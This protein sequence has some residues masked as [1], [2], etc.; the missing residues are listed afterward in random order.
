MIGRHTKE[1]LHKLS[2]K[3]LILTVVCFG[4]YTNI[5]NDL[6]GSE[7]PTMSWV[8]LFVVAFF[9]CCESLFVFFLTDKDVTKNNH[10]LILKTFSFL[11]SGLIMGV[12]MLM[13]YAIIYF[14]RDVIKLKLLTQEGCLIGI[15]SIFVLATF[16]CMNYLLKKQLVGEK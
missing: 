4:V 16:L 12:S 13:C 7:A 9:V 10:W 3:I 5:V 1:I 11:A 6:G 2:L 8:I 14:T 15:V